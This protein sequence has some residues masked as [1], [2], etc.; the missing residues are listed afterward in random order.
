MRLRAPALM[1]FVAFGFLRAEGLPVCLVDR[2]GLDPITL[3]AFEKEL[4]S[5]LPEGSAILHRAPCDVER[6][7]RSVRL[8]IRSEPPRQLPKALGVA[9]L[10]ATGQVLPILDV[11]LSRLSSYL[12]WP[13]TPYVVGRALARVAAHEFGHFLVQ[14]A[15]HHQDGLM[16]SQFPYWLLADPD[17]TPFRMAANARPPFRLLSSR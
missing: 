13:R 11:Y 8:T 3:S 10:S 15:G 14:D 7:T 9:Y 1:A 2:A 16:R 12:N 6:P 4:Q 5:L 17:P